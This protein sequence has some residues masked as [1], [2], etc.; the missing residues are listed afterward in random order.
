MQVVVGADVKVMFHGGA[1]TEDLR[2]AAKQK[3]RAIGGKHEAAQGPTIINGKSNAH[4][5]K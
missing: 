2:A 4:I 3:E 1:T 5:V